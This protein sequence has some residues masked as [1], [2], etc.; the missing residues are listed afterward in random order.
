MIL[1]RKP[2]CEFVPCL[3]VIGVRMNGDLVLDQGRIVPPARYPGR[4]VLPT[5]GVV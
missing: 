4:I 2:A 5:S 3:G 1:A